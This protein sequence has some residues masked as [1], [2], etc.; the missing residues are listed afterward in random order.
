M[1]SSHWRS[2]SH[3]RVHV[4]NLPGLLHSTKSHRRGK[5]HLQLL[6][7]SQADAAMWG[8]IRIHF[9]AHPMTGSTGVVWERAE[10]RSGCSW[11]VYFRADF[12][13]KEELRAMEQALNSTIHPACLQEPP[14]AI[15][16]IKRK[17]PRSCSLIMFPYQ[18]AKW[19]QRFTRSSSWASGMVGLISFGNRTKYSLTHE[20]SNVC[21]LWGYSNV[22]NTP[23]RALL[24]SNL[25]AHLSLRCPNRD[26]CLQF[27]PVHHAHLHVLPVPAAVPGAVR[28]HLQEAVL[29][30]E[31]HHHLD[32]RRSTSKHPHLRSNRLHSVK[33]RDTLI[34]FCVPTVFV[35]LKLIR[36]TNLM[37]CVTN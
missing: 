26:G 7:S 29:P 1:S 9:V 11:L 33:S 31:D 12:V 20:K 28:L 15:E 3:K 6:E 32:K 35:F 37:N 10:I 30:Q 25:S 19:Q 24:C 5:V 18:A 13:K 16:V 36:L 14:L 34:F 21:S 23:V 27:Q 4:L 17:W 22:H 8:R 2:P